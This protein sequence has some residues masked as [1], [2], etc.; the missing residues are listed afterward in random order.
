L[1]KY[2]SPIMRD[3][4][5][6]GRTKIF[7]YIL[8]GVGV[9]SAAA[10]WFSHDPLHMKFWGNWLHN[11]VFF[12]GIAAVALFF[13][14]AQ[15]TAFAGWNALVRRVWEAQSQFIIIGMLLFLP[16]IAALF[17]HWH[18]M[19]HWN[20]E[21][22]ADPNSP[23]YDK[24]IAGKSGFLN[25]YFY[26]FATVLI[27]G[28]WYLVA[29][30][31][32]QHSID[33]DVN[34]TKDYRQYKRIRT[35]S[36]IYLPLFGFTNIVLSWQ[37]LMSLDAHWYSTMYGWYS[38]AS[39]FLA[40]ISLTIILVIWLK[41]K[42]YLEQVTQEHLH[43]L[44]KY[45]F[46]ITVFWTY[47]W[48]D[49]YMLIWYANIGEETIYFKERW[50]QYPLLHG[51]NLII[52]FVMPFLILMRNDT[53]RKYGT[54][55]F[56]GILV[57]LGHWWD[58]F[59]MIKPS[60]RISLLEHTMPAH[61]GA[62]HDTHSMQIEDVK[63]H[64][65][66]HGTETVTTKMDDHG[67]KV[68]EV[69]IDEKHET[70]DGHLEEKH[71]EKVMI[72]DADHAHIDE[73]HLPEGAVKTVK[74]LTDTVG[75]KIIKEKEMTVELPAMAAHGDEHGGHGEHG[76][77]IEIHGKKPFEMGWTMPSFLD[78]GMMIGWL[79]LFLFVVLSHLEKAALKPKNDPWMDESEHHQVL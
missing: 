28:A 43:D 72:G 54:L 36:A 6:E 21:G 30:K 23:H 41:S 61:H 29:R 49:Q 40:M 58:M 70:A 59:Q 38:W 78:L 22:V 14:A 76:E 4:V 7:T 57:F 25:K 46:G 32:R 34:G 35:L 48:Y 65:T 5:F 37:W 10:L 73:N 51:G 68:V 66:E 69:K 1:K 20:V 33:Q 50:Y 52:N 75:G 15:I 12:T 44:G 16:L 11:S 53:K 71:I 18:H 63:T 27:L 77:T 74:E 56:V 62:G 47:L 67:Q 26:A 3:F 31:I 2:S 17:G 19:Y 55:V 8:M 9:V 45:M 64:A 42:G 13:L 39:M 24:I 60:T 79:G